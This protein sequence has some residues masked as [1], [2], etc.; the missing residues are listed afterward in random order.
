MQWSNLQFDLYCQFLHFIKFQC[1]LKW[2]CIAKSGIPM[3]FIACLMQ[4]LPLSKDLKKLKNLSFSFKV[5][6]EEKEKS[7]DSKI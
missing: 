7:N 3:V 4:F 6:I 1:F 2:S 5:I